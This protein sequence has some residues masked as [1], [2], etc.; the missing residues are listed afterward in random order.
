MRQWLEVSVHTCVCL[1]VLPCALTAV[2]S[3]TQAQDQ[4]TINSKRLSDRML[5]TWACDYFQGT[6]M[7]VIIGEQGLVIVDTGLSPSTVQRQRE[8]VGRVLGRSDFKYVINTH[9]HNDHAFANQV[10][11]EA[12]VV[13]HGDGVAA[14]E[15]EVDLIPELMER[16]RTSQERYG[17]WA[18][19]T[20]PDSLEGKHAR[21]GVAAFAVG[22]ADL[23]DGIEPRYPSLTFEDHHTLRLGDVRLELFDFVG[24]HSNSD[25]LILVPEERVLFT[26]DVFWGGQLPLLREESAEAFPRL[27]NNW[28]KILDTSPDLEVVVPGHSDVPLTVNQ[29][30]GMYQ[31][32]SRLWEDVQAAR[33]AG[34]PLRTF[35]MRSVFAERYPEVADYNYIRREYNL[36]QHNVYILWQLAG[37]LPPG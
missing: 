28:K 5:V 17:E 10:F 22:I 23:E 20:S 3:P 18:A 15:R 12:T 13:A 19:G 37:A 33:K 24:L 4:I 14:L 36:H 34:T 32:L 6:N 25:I 11:P 16:L 27:L 1:C 8:L 2:A 7:A 26:G 29:F 35:L 21:E 30:Q 9:M 31:Y